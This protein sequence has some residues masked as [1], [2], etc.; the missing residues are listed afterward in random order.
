MV[1]MSTTAT[2][3]MEAK[4]D[5]AALKSSQHVLVIL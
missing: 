2:S 4:N 1:N 3:I 5:R